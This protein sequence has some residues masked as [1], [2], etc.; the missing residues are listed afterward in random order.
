MPSDDVMR[1]VAK[2]VSGKNWGDILVLR[3]EITM[4][5]HVGWHTILE[6]IYKITGFRGQS[7]CFFYCFSLFSILRCPDIFFE[8]AGSMAHYSPG[9]CS[10][11]FSCNVSDI[12]G[13]AFYLYYG[14]CSLFSDFLAA[15]QDKNHILAVSNHFNYFDSFGYVDSWPVVYVCPAGF[16]FFSC[17]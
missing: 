15:F 3:P 4:D 8:K 12:F 10:S 16:V 11:N 6:F 17:P 1:H 9:Y 2:A 7:C 5:S 13:Q 14:G